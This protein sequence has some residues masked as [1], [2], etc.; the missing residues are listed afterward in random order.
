MYLRMYVVCMYVYYIYRHTFHDVYVNVYIYIYIYIYMY[1]Y[2]HIHNI[3]V[4]VYMHTK[5]M[6]LDNNLYMYHSILAN[7][8][9]LAEYVNDVIVHV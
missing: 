2:T 5:Q 3:G 6:F 1:M 4:R 9:D 8:P 7:L